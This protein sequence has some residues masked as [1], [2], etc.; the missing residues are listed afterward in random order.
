MVMLVATVDAVVKLI[1]VR[2]ALEVANETRAIFSV[3]S[4]IGMVTMPIDVLGRRRRRRLI[5]SRR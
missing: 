1:R 5:M 2:K 3:S 4:D